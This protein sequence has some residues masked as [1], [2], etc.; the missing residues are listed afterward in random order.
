MGISYQMEDITSTCILMI[1]QVS[2]MIRDRNRRFRV[3]MREG[4][5][6]ILFSVKVKRL[7]I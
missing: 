7:I 5:I 6:H 1:S 2:K 4:I 3:S